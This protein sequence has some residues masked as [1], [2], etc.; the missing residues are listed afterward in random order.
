M[1]RKTATIKS[2]F[3]SI[4]GFFFSIFLFTLG[5][6]FLGGINAFF[7]YTNEMEFCTS[8]HTMKVNLEEY[9]QTIHYKNASGVQATCS[10]CHVPKQFI[11]KVTA[12]IYAVKDI[13]HEIIGTID[14]KEK[15]EAH[16]WE[17]ASRV[18]KKME[19]TDSRECRNCHDFNN[20][21][22]ESQDRSAKKK[23]GRAPMNGSTCIDC[24][25]GIAHEEP[26]EPDEIEEI[27]IEKTKH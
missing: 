19:E 4:K 22:L 20:M 11:P 10:D 3:F 27:T 9:K 14:S 24:H 21:D 25:K 18:W 16:R 6:T 23:H 8:C 7:Q 15:Y 5:V 2:F 13:Y 1:I 26:E 12:K 17:M